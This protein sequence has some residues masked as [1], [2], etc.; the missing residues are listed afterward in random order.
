MNLTRT[1]FSIIKGKNRLLSTFTCFERA[2]DGKG[3][4]ES[5]L[6]E[7]FLLLVEEA[8]YYKKNKE[9]VI[10]YLIEKTKPR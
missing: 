10:L 6:R 5:E 7:L 1:S 3:I 4:P 8:D 2:I 9:K